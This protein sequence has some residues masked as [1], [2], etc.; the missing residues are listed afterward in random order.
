MVN[1]STMN[2]DVREYLRI[3]PI[4]VHEL[5]LSGDAKDC[6]LLLREHVEGETREECS[7]V[8]QK[9]LFWNLYQSIFGNLLR[10]S[11]GDI[12]FRIDHIDHNGGDLLVDWE[13]GVSIGDDQFK[14]YI[15][16]SEL[17]E[18]QNDFESRLSKLETDVKDKITSLRQRAIVGYG[19]AVE[20]QTQLANTV[21]NLYSGF[22]CGVGHIWCY[23]GSSMMAE[24][25]DME[26]LE[27]PL[28][29]THADTLTEAMT[30]S[31]ATAR[32]GS[33]VIGRFVQ[34]SKMRVAQNDYS[35]VN[36][37][38]LP[39]LQ[40]PELGTQY[41]FPLWGQNVLDWRDDERRHNN[42]PPSLNIYVRYMEAHPRTGADEP[43][44][45]KRMRSA[46]FHSSAEAVH[47]SYVVEEIPDYG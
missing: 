7:V 6:F 28:Q 35:I 13:D 12:G 36:D 24:G 37:T 32:G 33:K 16:K 46:K 34:G 5:T 39:M 15:R 22:S 23:N 19:G 44:A 20:L 30:S 9:T 31:F 38:N 45:T 4:S 1:S 17:Q 42:M 18:F 21:T 29:H 43:V 26:T 14:N 3:N 2:V 8:S 10:S 25:M 40:N 27:H 47:E 11:I 41:T